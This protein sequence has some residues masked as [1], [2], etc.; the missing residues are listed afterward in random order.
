M[1][2]DGAND[3]KVEDIRRA[4]DTCHMDGMGG[5]I[6]FT[7][8]SSAGVAAVAGIGPDVQMLN[9]DRQVRIDRTAQG[10]APYAVTGA[11]S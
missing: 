6:T 5:S 8:R 3:A 7:G 2:S 10:V 1:R 9:P 4:G 11:R